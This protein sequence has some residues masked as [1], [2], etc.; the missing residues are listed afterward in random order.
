MCEYKCKHRGNLQQP[1]PEA[2]Y[3]RY[4]VFLQQVRIQMQDP[5]QFKQH[6]ANKHNIRSRACL[7]CGTTHRWRSACLACGAT[8]RW[9]LQSMHQPIHSMQAPHLSFLQLVGTRRAMSIINTR[10]VIQGATAWRNTQ[11]QSSTYRKPLWDLQ[12]SRCS[13]W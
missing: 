2:Q 8:H 10:Q 3:Q 9:R 7:A 6:L 5:W 4:I 13:N 11:S 12:S 1:Y